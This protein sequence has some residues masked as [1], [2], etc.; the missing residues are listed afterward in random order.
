VLEPQYDRPVI[1][2]LELENGFFFS[3]DPI[4]TEKFAALFGL[5]IEIKTAQL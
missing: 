3:V 4:M 1:G 2:W 5:L